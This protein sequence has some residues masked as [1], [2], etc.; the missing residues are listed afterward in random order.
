ML[1]DDVEA[2]HKFYMEYAHSLAFSVR[3]GQQKL[4]ANGVVIW[5]RF[6]CAREGYKTEKE[7]GASGSSSKGRRSRESRCG[8][9]AY[10]YV[11]RTPEGKYVIAALHE[12]HNH[13]FVTPSKPFCQ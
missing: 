9:P 12:E 10:I 7:E 13:S 1:F 6:L 3:I 8:C 5:K 11:K 2:A 4:D